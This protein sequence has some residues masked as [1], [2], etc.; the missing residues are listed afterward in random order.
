MSCVQDPAPEHPY[1]LASDIEEGHLGQ[2]ER[3]V[4]TGERQ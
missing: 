1:P 4:G 2:P 3:L